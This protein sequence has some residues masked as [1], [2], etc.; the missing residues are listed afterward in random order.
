MVRIR[1]RV[2]RIRVR[3]VRKIRVEVQDRVRG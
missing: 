2:V 3:V 1:I